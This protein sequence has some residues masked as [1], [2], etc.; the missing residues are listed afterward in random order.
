MNI[1]TLASAAGLG[2]AAAAAGS[3]DAVLFLGRSPETLVGIAAAAVFVAQRDIAETRAGRVSKALASAGLAYALAPD[4][5]AW[6]GVS[7]TLTGAC[8]CMFSVVA[9]DTAHALIADREF[10]KGLLRRRGDDK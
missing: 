8:V 1:T 9:I 2:V 4:L 5:A 3:P 7:I 6:A 10:I